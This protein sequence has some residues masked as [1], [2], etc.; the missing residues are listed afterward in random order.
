MSER[1]ER[2]KKQTESLDS[3]V[4]ELKKASSADQTQIKELRMKLR[5]SE[6]ERA[7]LSGKQGEA[8]DFKKV[9]QAL[10]S[11][12]KDENKEKDKK[13]ADLER[14]LS[15]ETKKKE[16]IELQLRDIE[17]RRGERAQ[18]A[19]PNTQQLENQIKDAQDKAKQAHCALQALVCEASTREQELLSQ[20]EQYRSLVDSIAEEYGRLASV[21]VPASVHSD[22]KCRNTDLQLRHFR[23]ERKLAN[24]EGQVVEL[25]N[26]VR[27][28]EHQNILLS[29]QLEEAGEE[30]EFYSDALAHVTRCSQ[31]YLNL[32]DE[33]C[34]R[35]AQSAVAAEIHECREGDLEMR[36]LESEVVAQFQRVVNEELSQLYW[37][38][39]KCLDESEALIQQRTITL[40]AMSTT[41]MSLTAQ[42]ETA[43]V[44]RERLQSQ[45]SA[46]LVSN[47]D[48]QETSTGLELRLKE[49]ESKR[50]QESAEHE[51]MLKKEHHIVQ[52][53]TSTVQK[54]RAAE[55][56]L[57]AE[58][59][60]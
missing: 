60:Q 27:C 55:E 44:E 20:L 11:R 31:D 53:L 23:L 10:E 43:L 35:D 32:A 8:G 14:A 19:G 45:H 6:H 34:L 39:E 42:L 16:A 36:A 7:Q 3:R 5:M 28:T 56:S 30:L 4:Q 48:L 1:L 15:I 12:R 54:S 41:Q 47:Q 57:R 49:E 17:R 40:E 58:I 25:T 29:T 50:R 26:L 13:I 18:G 59:E 33:P 37:S 22:L 38:A 24:V 21:T 51:K 46:L 2:H 9:L 52:N